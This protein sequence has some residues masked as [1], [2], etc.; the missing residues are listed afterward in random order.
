MI[1]VIY[2]LIHFLN[3][4]CVNLEDE[5]AAGLRSAQVHSSQVHYDLLSCGKKNHKIEMP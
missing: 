2:D 5:F 1:K 3:D 4:A